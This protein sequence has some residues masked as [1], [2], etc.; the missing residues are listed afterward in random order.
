ME[1]IM[2]HLSLP[3]EFKHAINE[4][5]SLQ[6]INEIPVV[7]VKHPQ[8]NAV[9][10]LQGAHLISWQPHFCKQ[11]VLWV[12]EI[13]PFELQSAI[14]GGVPICYPWFKDAGT[15]SHGYARISLWHLSRWKNDD[16]GV[17]LTF[18]LFDENNIAEVEL[19]MTIGE[20]CYMR[21]H[22]FGNKPAQGA[23]HS[24]FN[25]GDIQQTALYNMP[26]HCLNSLTGKDEP[27]DSPR[28]FKNEV[29]CIYQFADNDSLIKDDVWQRE[30]KIAHQHNSDVVVWNPWHRTTSNM[31]EKGFK[32][33][34]CV[35]TARLSKTLKQNDSF[36]VTFSIL[37][38]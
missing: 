38:K 13:E 14:R 28:Y 9:I 6:K 16:N 31:D 7:V 21:L 19:I 30:I 22:H 15:P 5:L 36:E 8:A 25:V 2:Q 12:S 20:Q 11:D 27:V 33:M 1:T 4:Y 26:N 35:E 29:D 23:L 3:F 10:S 17:T 32:H 24:Y 37:Q 34:L 18:T